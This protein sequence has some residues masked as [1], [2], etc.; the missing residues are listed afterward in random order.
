LF[1]AVG[2]ASDGTTAALLPAFKL[3]PEELGLV[4]R[5]EPVDAAAAGADAPMLP[6]EPEGA[7][8]AGADD[9]SLA[10][11]DSCALAIRAVRTSGRAK[12]AAA[13]ILMKRIV[14]SFSVVGLTR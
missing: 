6:L 13:T 9:L 8:A 4:L 12:P 14:T 11:P 5:L 1:I 7:L 10:L 3:G 2:L